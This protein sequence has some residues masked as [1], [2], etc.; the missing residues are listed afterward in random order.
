MLRHEVIFHSQLP[1]SPVL[2][3]YLCIVYSVNNIITVKIRQLSGMGGLTVLLLLLAGLVE[4]AWGAPELVS[5]VVHHT[6]VS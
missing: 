3:G 5:L 1:H 2:I 6:A 4:A